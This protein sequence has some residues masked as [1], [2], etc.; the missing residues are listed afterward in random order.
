ALER[1]GRLAGFSLTP[2]GRER[3]AS[4]LEGDS[5]RARRDELAG[6]YER[7]E[8]VNAT[9]KQL[10]TDWQL[11]DGERP[12][13]HSDPGYDQAVL[14][15][16]GGIHEQAMELLAEAG[17]ERLERYAARLASSA[18]AVAAGDTRRFT[19]PL[20]ESYHDVWM[21]LHHDLLTSFGLKRGAGDA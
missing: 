19:A 21:E 11:V 4:A 3:H 5:L 1:T 6:W 9:F 17:H 14:G 18:A 2:A 10:C 7:F 8:V 15:R 12:N 13:D 16:L 20:C